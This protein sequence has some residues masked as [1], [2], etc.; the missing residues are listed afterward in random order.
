MRAAGKLK[1]LV[2]RLTL[3]PPV[4]LHSESLV[5]RSGKELFRGQFVMFSSCF[6]VFESAEWS[7]EWGSVCWVCPL[8]SCQEL[9]VK[10]LCFLNHSGCD[11]IMFSLHLNNYYSVELYFDFGV[12][13]QL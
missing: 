5:F 6:A 2:V 12:T 10:Q 9:T 11:F 7:S 13:F 4:G 3:H 8:T 1:G